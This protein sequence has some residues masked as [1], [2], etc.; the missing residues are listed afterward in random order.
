MTSRPWTCPTCGAE[1]HLEPAREPI[2][3]RPTNPD[4]DEVELCSDRQGKA[5][6]ALG[7]ELPGKKEELLGIIH[8]DY[9]K[10]TIDALTI[11][12]ASALITR[13]QRRT[14]R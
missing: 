13:L 10:D 1:Y 12:E 11:R 14:R 2:G 8:M 9:G 5:L 4:Q 3:T 6:Y 7:Q